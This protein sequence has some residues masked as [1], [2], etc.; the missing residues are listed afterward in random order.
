MKCID[1]KM[2][3]LLSTHF[4]VDACHRYGQQSPFPLSEE[5]KWKFQWWLERVFGLNLRN[6]RT[7]NFKIGPVTFVDSNL[8]W[9]PEK[10]DEFDMFCVRQSWSI[11]Y[12]WR[13][14]I[15]F[16]RSNLLSD[17][18]DK[19]QFLNL[20]FRV[21]CRPLS[22]K[23]RSCFAQIAGFEIDDIKTFKW[24]SDA[25]NFMLKSIRDIMC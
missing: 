18:G 11:W 21:G 19:N 17:S 4:K 12:S 15:C 14:E 1:S 7:M 23:S 10:V 3:R 2:R 16:Y 6:H 22:G 24:L 9:T 20:K 5:G 25:V 13:K 8:F